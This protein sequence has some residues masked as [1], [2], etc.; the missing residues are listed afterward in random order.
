VLLTALCPA[1]ATRRQIDPI[2]GSRAC[3]R[4]P[5][6]Q[7]ASVVRPTQLWMPC[8]RAVLWDELPRQPDYR[9]EKGV[10][11]AD[12]LDECVEAD[13]LGHIGVGVEVIAAYYVFVGL[14]GG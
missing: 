8:C 4:A 2:D 1:R 13:W 3:R 7:P 10:D 14:R 6:R 12:D 9:L 11:F 5:G